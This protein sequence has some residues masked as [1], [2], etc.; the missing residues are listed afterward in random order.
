[1]GEDMSASVPTTAPPGEG[2]KLWSLPMQNR[3]PGYVHPYAYVEVEI[4]RKGWRET[5]TV[6]PRVMHPAT[7]V[8]GLHWRPAGDRL[9][10]NAMLRWALYG[11]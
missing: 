8:I 11:R 9:T 5:K 4:W 7:N 2:W 3:A 10:G 1:M 6:N